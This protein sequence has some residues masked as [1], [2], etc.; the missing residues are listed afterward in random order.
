M[1]IINM[2]I[3]KQH[4]S[5]WHHNSTSKIGVYFLSFE[6]RIIKI[7]WG[8]GVVTWSGPP[9]PLKTISAFTHPIFQ[10]ALGKTI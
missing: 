10:I 3:P 6:R 7:L 4:I 5:E 8:G 2:K 1:V 9:P